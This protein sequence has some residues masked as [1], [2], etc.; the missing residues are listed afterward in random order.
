[1]SAFDSE[2]LREQKRA[3]EK[4]DRKREERRMKEDL[5]ELAPKAD[6]GS[7]QARM[8]KRAE[9]GSYC[10]C[11]C[12]CVCVCVVRAAMPGE[13]HSGLLARVVCITAKRRLSIIKALFQTIGKPH[14]R[15]ATTRELSV[16]LI[17]AS[18]DNDAQDPFDSYPNVHMNK[19]SDTRWSATASTQAGTFCQL[20][21]SP[22]LYDAQEPTR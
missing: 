9:K 21:T 12:V 18:D 11:V 7:V 4:L 5:E 2:E 15:T 1:M 3:S 17:A 22:H 14:M 16:L 13:W 6:P 8:E 10:R 19:S 20:H